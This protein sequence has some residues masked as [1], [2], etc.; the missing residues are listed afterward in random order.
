[1]QFFCMSASTKCRLSAFS[2]CRHTVAPSALRQSAPKEAG[3]AETRT[4]S[5]YLRISTR[6]LM[7]KAKAI[8]LGSRNRP[9]YHM[10]RSFW[11]P[12]SPGRV[13]ARQDYPC[14]AFPF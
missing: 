5:C 14:R 7:I 12:A 3:R 11:R 13:G 8:T 10:V 9:W 2:S 6:T 4:A 1:M